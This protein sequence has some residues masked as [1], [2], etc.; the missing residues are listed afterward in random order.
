[1][2][3][4][5]DC[6]ITREVPQQMYALWFQVSKKSNLEWRYLEKSESHGKLVSGLVREYLDI[7]TERKSYLTAECDEPVRE[8]ARLKALLRQHG[9]DPASGSDRD[10]V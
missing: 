1:M 6:D 3:E 9:I 10:R 5:S 8:V 7:E 4:L 2:G